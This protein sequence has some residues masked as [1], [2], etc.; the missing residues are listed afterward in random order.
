VARSH[1]R[2]LR[3]LEL[4]SLCLQIGPAVAAS[5]TARIGRH[6]TGW[7]TVAEMGSRGSFADGAERG[8]VVEL[9]VAGC[10]LIG[11]ESQCQ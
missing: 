9:L 1:P 8:L 11:R 2:I 6:D 3:K 10:D 5:G 7:D 4:M